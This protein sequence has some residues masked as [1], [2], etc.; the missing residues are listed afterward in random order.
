[1]AK[2]DQIACNTAEL[3]TAGAVPV[4]PRYGYESP[5]VAGVTPGEKRPR[6]VSQLRATAAN[7]PTHARGCDFDAHVRRSG[8][9][10][11]TRSSS[12][13]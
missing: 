12:R 10:T 6:H 5:P 3:T 7:T 13:H 1:M 4:R 11:S 2:T 9:S 8:R